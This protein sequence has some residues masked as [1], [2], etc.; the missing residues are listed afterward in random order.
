[1]GKS[2]PTAPTAPNPTQTTQQQQAYNL[3]TAQQNAEL[4]RVNQQTAQ[5]SLQYQVTGTNPDGTPQ[6]T[7]TQ[8]Y[9]PTQQG[10]YNSQTGLQQSLYNT[11]NNN[12][13]GQVNQSLSSPYDISN[14]GQIQY[15]ASGAAGGSINNQYG[16][17]GPI[18]TSLNFS[19]LPAIPQAGDF[20][21][22]GQQIN[23]SVYNQ[24][25]SRLDPQWQL[26]Q[27]Q[28]ASTL[29]AKGVTEGS[30]A[31]QNAMDEFQRQKTDAYNQ[32]TYSGIQQGAAEQQ[33][34]F[35]MALQGRQQGVAET[36]AQGQFAN[37]AQQQG[38]LQ[39]LQAGT[40]GNTAQQQAYTQSLQ[41]ANLNNA[42]QAQAVSQY[43]TQRNAPLTALSSLL[44]N[45]T[46]AGGVQNPN[47]INA[48]QANVAGV[49]YAGMVQD[50]Y[51]NQMKA[52]QQQL[53]QQ[54]SALGG[55]FGL[56]GSVASVIPG[57]GAAG[58]LFSGGLGGGGGG[59]WA[60]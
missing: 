3:Q 55:L 37:Q 60:F 27:Q 18:Q 24:A 38:N 40:F 5:G 58:G 36:A 49:N 56:A 50:N 48:P 25:T 53:A 26:Q 32:A 22:M 21:S 42:A 46:G 23:N 12:L 39:N 10:L 57:V 4:N 34:L 28:L 51:D 1:M 19:N 41:N 14:L 31:Y 33:Q 11:A 29:A 44:G 43:G 2:T 52:Y 54:Q 8:S 6:Y 45:V 9:S 13:A 15:G 17:G 7:A 35:G 16:S 30:Q 47:Y 59:G 20:A